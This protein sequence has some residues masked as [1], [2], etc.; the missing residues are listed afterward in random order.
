MQD[1]CVGCPITSSIEMLSWHGF[2][3]IATFA[4]AGFPTGLSWSQLGIGNEGYHA[5]RVSVLKYISPTIAGFSL[6]A[7]IN[8]A[9]E[10]STAYGVDGV[11]HGYDWDIG[12]RYA[13]EFNGVRVAWGA[14]Y[15][16]NTNVDGLGNDGDS[17]IIVGSMQHVPTGL[18]IQANYKESDGMVCA[19]C[20][21]TAWSVTAGIVRKLSPL[22]S[23][24]FWG[25]Y[26]SYETDTAAIDS[27][28]NS[29]FNRAASGFF[30]NNVDPL[31]SAVANGD[32][33][34]FGVNQKIDAAAME[35][36]LTYWNVSG[37]IS[38]KYSGV[39]ITPTVDLETSHFVMAGARINF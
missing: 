3:A 29:A 9:N 23:T 26:S 37:D 12:L 21:H 32:V 18:F 38:A 14:G 6:T 35:L 20:D 17:W 15:S 2:E 27:P 33:W 22:G 39:A 4:G 31:L 25:Q 7:S 8:D 34:A 16:E 24:T 30:G 28:A 10:T 19:Y 5:T 13:N 36:Y 1:I 11:E